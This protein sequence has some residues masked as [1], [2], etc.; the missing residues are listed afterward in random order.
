MQFLK[1]G[2]VP[3]RVRKRQPN[4]IE[5]SPEFKALVGALHRLAPGEQAGLSFDPID[6]KKLGIRWPARVAADSLRRWLT[7][8]R[9]SDFYRIRKF[10]IEGRQFVSVTRRKAPREVHKSAVDHVSSATEAKMA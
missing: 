5:R 8:T 9:L 10:K 6:Q 3:R 2:Q 7:E 1:P 4:V